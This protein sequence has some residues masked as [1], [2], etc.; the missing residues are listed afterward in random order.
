MCLIFLLLVVDTD[1]S[2]DVFLTTPSPPFSV[3][4]TAD[5]IKSLPSLLHNGIIF[6]HY[7]TVCLAVMKMTLQS[8]RQ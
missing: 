2:N 6:N 3:F 7:F 8:A 4:C 5:V 1:F